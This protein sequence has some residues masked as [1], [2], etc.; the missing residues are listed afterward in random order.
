MSDFDQALTLS[1][2]LPEK[3][4]ERLCS[5]LGMLLDSP[6]ALLDERGAVLGGAHG[7]P[8]G[9]RLD[10]AL[11]LEPIGY[12]QAP[13]ANP[14]AQ[15]AAVSLVRQLLLARARYLMA[16][17][18][19]LA[20]TQ[21]DY[22]ELQRQNTALRESEAKYKALSAE[23]EARVAAQLKVL[24]ERQRQL[25]QAERLASVGQLAAGVAHEINNPIG[26][27]RSNL[28]T[29]QK[30][31]ARIESLAGAVKA[32]P[33]GEAAWAGADMAYT[34]EDFAD[35]LKDSISGVDRVA[36]IVTDLK[37]F[38]N[39]D[40]P[41]E[42][43]KDVNELLAGACNIIEPRL[44]DGAHLRR[45]F[46]PTPPLLCLPG[47]LSQAFLAV[48]GNAVLAIADKG[49]E[50]E[51]LASIGQDHGRIVTRIADNGIGIDP[52]VQARIFDPFFTTRPVGQGTGLGLTVAR[53][54]VRVHGGEIE[55]DSTPGVGTTVLITLPVD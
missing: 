22:D 44:A 48:L 5:S 53:D 16:S 47:H 14:V 19:H 15:G 50:G 42:E 40:K 45:D 32:L 21:A 36:R 46:Q 51:V 9:S 10:L 43:I 18:V 49:P 2:L 28:S 7:L 29:A 1:G 38:S 3:D 25:Y 54:I 35:L 6:V 23:L 34:L 4:I 11:E 31:L 33:G 24:D 17:S 39:V 26:F 52:G 37:G 27:V 13:A 30:Y 41:Q 12:L 55:I 20:A 8:A